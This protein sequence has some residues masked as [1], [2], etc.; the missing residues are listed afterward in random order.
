[1]TTPEYYPMTVN[2]LVLA[3]NQK[4]NREPVTDYEEETIDTALGEL[5]RLGLARF[6]RTAGAR[7]LKYLHKADDV[8]QIDDEQLA[9]V[10]V[11]LLRGPQTPGELR[12]R[13]ERYV[14]FTSIEAVEQRLTDLVDRDV[15]LVERLEREPGR[16]EARYRTLLAERSVDVPR[17]APA[18]DGLESR[19]VALE[20]RLTRIES[21]LGIGDRNAEFTVG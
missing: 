18:G 8:L 15:P 16:K 11:L 1:M 12:A 17:P 20:E 21:E 2:A 5:N 6:T 3:C 19:V 9:L 14:A 13:T 4:T 10:A 7:S